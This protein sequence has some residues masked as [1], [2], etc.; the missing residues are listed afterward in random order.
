[1]QNSDQ[2]KTP[3]SDAP[4]FDEDSTAELIRILDHTI[5][6]YQR[7]IQEHSILVARQNQA[8]L[9]ADRAPAADFVIRRAA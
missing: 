1:M 6:A 8:T 5:A 3:P 2:S 4:G 7:K 9:D